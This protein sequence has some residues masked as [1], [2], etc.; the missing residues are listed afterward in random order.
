MELEL[1]RTSFFGRPPSV[2]RSAAS[3]WDG[4]FDPALAERLAAE[5]RGGA[6][7][8]WSASALDSWSQCAHQYFQRHVLRLRPPDERPLE[9]EART[10]GDLAHLT[11]K[12]LLEA[13]PGSS[14]LESVQAAVD[15]AASGVR[16]DRRGPP[17]VWAL[18]RRRVAAAIHRYLRHVAEAESAA[19]R[20]PV[21][22]ETSF[23]RDDSTVPGV[24]IETR[25]G[26]VSLRGTID[27]L[28]RHPET[29]DLHV[30]DYKYS[31]KK[32]D[33]EEAV[34]PERCGVERF[35]LHAYFLGALAWAEAG[36]GRPAAVSAAIHCVRSPA[37]VGPLEMP[38][39]ELVRAGIARAVEAAAAGTFDPTPRDPKS[40]R[41]CD[42][43]RSCRIAT[44]PGAMAEEEEDE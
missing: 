31:F 44:V 7:A 4:A 1:A 41:Y 18:T 36:G 21:A 22:F 39:Q 25:H 19:G 17:V 43:R 24:A 34:D 28:D 20:V 32:K 6:L 27:R 14:D 2:R 35:Q 30:V 40:C 11:L 8:A 33:H 16:D 26:T 3:R 13:G 15:A 10:V 23:G 37:V 42:F 9:A 12:R 29:G 38:D 5:V